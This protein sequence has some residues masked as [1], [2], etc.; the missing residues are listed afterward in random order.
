LVVVARPRIM[1]E[2]VTWS[3]ETICLHPPS[4][5]AEA[6]AASL[7]DRTC[8]TNF[9]SPGFCAVDAGS[10]V[11][12]VGLR[13]LMVQIKREMASIHES[14][15]GNTL[16]Y[17]SAARFDQQETTR[18]HLDGGPEECFLMLGY[19]PS[20]VDSELEIFDYARCAFDLG[21]SPQQFMAKYN[22]MFT[23]GH[24]EL[25]PYAT[26]VPCF[27]RTHYQIIC[28]NNS[29]APCSEASPAWQGTLHTATILTP[30]DSQQRVINSTMIAAV[31]LGT[32]ETVNDAAQ[33]EFIT[34]SAVRRRGY[35]KPHL[36]DET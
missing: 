19:E 11:D 26:R 12:S 13:K 28:I 27:S 34:T 14:K 29:S 8:R 24:E 1:T 23:S 18:P 32:P 16:V 25:R 22:P 33:A 31:P 36:E 35:D 17:L 2:A 15:T 30:D 4:L 20:A 21:I 10:L 5:D 3:P 7:Y 6:L 9:D